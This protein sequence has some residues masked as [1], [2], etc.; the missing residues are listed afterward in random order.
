MSQFL[1]RDYLYI[2]INIDLSSYLFIIH[3]SSIMYY[4]CLYFIVINTDMYPLLDMFSLEYTGMPHSLKEDFLSEV[5]L[6]LIQ[7]GYLLNSQLIHEK[8]LIIINSVCV[9]VY[10]E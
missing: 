1:V 10:V 7:L 9:C 5:L 4:L 2:Y 8:T 3:L 6:K